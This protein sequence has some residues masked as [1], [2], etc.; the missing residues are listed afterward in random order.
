MI[1]RKCPQ[2]LSEYHHSY[3]A[4]SLQKYEVSGI[5][6]KQ[7]TTGEYRHGPISKP[8]DS[9]KCEQPIYLSLLPVNRSIYSPTQNIEKH[10][11]SNAL[12]DCFQTKPNKFLED[13]P[14]QHPKLYESLKGKQHT[15][16]VRECE[17]RKTTV[18]IDFGHVLEYPTGPYE[19][20]NKDERHVKCKSVH[21]WHLVDP[22][23]KTV[24]SCDE[25]LDTTSCTSNYVEPSALRAQTGHFPEIWPIIFPSRQ[26]KDI[27]QTKQHET[28]IYFK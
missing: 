22:C 27:T 28:L 5:K 21:K 6:I 20:H 19:N 2:Y 17:R 25:Q 12:L 4:P 10:Q 1:P 7:K 23:E 24:A 14:Q 9:K 11:G 16:T 15:Q 18:Q 13:L 26:F 8:L 3:R